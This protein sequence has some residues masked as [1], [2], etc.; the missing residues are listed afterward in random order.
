MENLTSCANC[1]AATAPKTMEEGLQPDHIAVTGSPNTT[2]TLT[3]GN[4]RR[5]LCGFSETNA[6]NPPPPARRND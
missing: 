6:T 2:T 4:D 1:C 3:Y 5:G